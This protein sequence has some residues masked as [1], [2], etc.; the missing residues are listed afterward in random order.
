MPRRRTW[1]KN[2]GKLRLI[3]VVLRRKGVCRGRGSPRLGVRSADP[4]SG[5][6][7][8]E[9]KVFNH[10]FLGLTRIK[11]SHP[12]PSKKSVVKCLPL[13]LAARGFWAVYAG[14][15]TLVHPK[16]GGGWSSSA[17]QGSLRSLIIKDM[18]IGTWKFLSGAWHAARQE[19]RPAT[20]LACSVKDA[21]VSMRIGGTTDPQRSGP[22]VPSQTG[23][24]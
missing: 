3:T 20:G 14:L 13:R 15:C 2:Y 7:D 23:T 12:C 24:K 4:V 19:R 22:S 1:L 21:P 6:P 18:Q 5:P 9:Q 10:G 11:T 16:K 8:A 17:G